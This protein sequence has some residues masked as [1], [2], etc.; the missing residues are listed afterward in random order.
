[1]NPAPGCVTLAAYETRVISRN[2]EH[3]IPSYLIPR[4]GGLERLYEPPPGFGDLLEFRFTATAGRGR[5][6]LRGEESRREDV[7]QELGGLV[8]L[9]GL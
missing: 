7:V 9:E 5:L 3:S 1:M 8:G 6:L 4:N 2:L